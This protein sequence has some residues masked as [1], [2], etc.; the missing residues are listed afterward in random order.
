MVQHK[1][2][3]KNKKL[4]LSCK[5][6]LLWVKLK[7]KI[8]DEQVFKQMKKDVQYLYF[9]KMLLYPEQKRKDQSDLLRLLLFTSVLYDIFLQLLSSWQSKKVSDSS[10][11][12]STFEIE[13]MEICLWVSVFFSFFLIID[14]V[15]ATLPVLLLNSCLVLASLS[16]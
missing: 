3:F 6:G 7:L 4:N 15:V 12:A 9:W 1:Y 14:Q 13:E 2:C 10:L 8:G 11:F 5:H 16:W